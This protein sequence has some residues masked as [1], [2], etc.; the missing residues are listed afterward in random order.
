MTVPRAPPR[1]VFGWP[2]LGLGRLQNLQRSGAFFRLLLRVL[3][4]VLPGPCNIELVDRGVIERTLGPA[5]EAPALQR[6]SDEVLQ[7]LRS[8][9]STIL[10]RTWPARGACFTARYAFSAS[11]GARARTGSDRPRSWHCCRRGD[12]LPAAPTA[13]RGRSVR[14]RRRG[15]PSCV[16]L[17]PVADAVTT[18]DAARRAGSASLSVACTRVYRVPVRLIVP[19][20]DHTAGANVACVA[21]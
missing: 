8:G 12:A 13:R 7:V 16:V 14:V 10:G 1:P 19:I 15:D 2:G 11:R 3:I 5:L 9:R 6:G 4:T 20:A 21:P 17:V 18:I